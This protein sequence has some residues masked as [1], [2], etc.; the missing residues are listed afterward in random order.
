MT[1][2]RWL[3]WGALVCALALTVPAAAAP[4]PAEQDKPLAQVPAKAPIVIQIRGFERTRERLNVLIK[5]ALPDFADLAKEKIDAALKEGLEGRELKGLI[6]D[7][8]IFFVFTE[9]TNLNGPQAPKA[10]ILLPVTRYESFRDGLLKDEERKSLKAEAAGYESVTL[11]RE[12]VYFVNRKNG[13]VVMTPDA[14]VAASFTKKYETLADK[15]SKPIARRL[16]EADVSVYVDMAEV[17]RQHGNDIQ[18]LRDAIEQG[19]DA[20]PDKNAAEQAKRLFAPFFQAVSDSTAV[21]ASADLRPEG[22]LLHVET[23]VPADSKTNA[24]LKQ[25]KS[26]PMADLSKLPGGQMVY[27]AMAFTP[28]VVKETLGP[29]AYGVMAD[30]DSKEG[31]AIHKAVGELAD[32]GPR[33]RLDASNIPMSGLQVWK[34]DNPSKAVSA[35]LNLFKALK[36]GGSYGAV[37]KGEPVIKE[38]A[39]KHAGFDFNFVSLKFDL[40]KTVER[41]GAALNDDQKKAMA[42]YLKAALGEGANIWFGTDGKTVLQVTGKDWP[43]AQAK[44]DRYLKGDGA[45]GQSQAF[46]DA[47]KQLPPD[48]SAL[49]LLDVPQ[50]SE[51]LV[52]MVVNMLQQSGLPV[53][54]PPGI[55][56]PAVKG[57][58][59]YLGMSVTLEPGRAGLDVWLAT[60]SVHDIYKMYLER[61]F[62]PGF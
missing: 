6:K 28:A 31:K 5:N 43:E 32:A 52:K 61:L 3:P 62:K 26:L 49:M 12:T 60:T 8:P 53:P 22:V 13:Y 15:V 38:G 42:E 56:K 16:M 34:Y 37:L 40:E 20:T 4:V 23:E 51:V 29:L 39:Q 59:S 24:L 47:A 50:Y 44:V 54:I 55:E 9:L 30:G 1:R 10:A 7:G 14:D 36:E 11:D 45:L 27:S 25:W 21:L 33:M 35:Q 19:I 58:T 48:A 17:N 2:H 46:K 57:N 41:Q 18:Q